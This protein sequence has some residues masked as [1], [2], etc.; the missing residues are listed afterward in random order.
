MG[1]DIWIGFLKIVSMLSAGVFVALGLVTKYKDENDKITKWGKTALAGI[2]IS[3]IIS[4]SLHI[5]ETSK[6]KN[7]AVQ[8]K[9]EADAT[10]NS[11]RTILETA[12]TTANQQKKSLDET[13]RLK[14][15]LEDTSARTGLI[16]DDMKIT[17]RQQTNLARGQ[18][19]AIAAQ[20][21]QIKMQ[22]QQLIL[23]RSAVRI[24][25]TLRPPS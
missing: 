8:S 22:E 18:E 13:N 3:T 1:F 20:L 19:T 2:F 16:A 6:A 25:A 7:A 9:T 21:Q 10:A 5:L 4:L 23:Q 12:Q 24:P 14:K 17:L 15:G 11:L